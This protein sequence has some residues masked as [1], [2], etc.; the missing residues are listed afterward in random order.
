[1]SPDAWM[2]G[3]LLGLTSGLSP[4]PLLTLVISETLRRGPGAGLKVAAAPLITDAPV[5]LATVLIF[6]RMADLMAVIGGISLVGAGALGYYAWES[7]RFAGAAESVAVAATPG[8]AAADAGRKRIDPSLVRGIVTNF[9]N[10]HLYL[11]WISV[12]GPLMSDLSAN[13]GMA[14]PAAFLAAFY[15]CL[16]GAKMVLALI[17]GRFRRALRSRGYVAVIRGLG[18]VLLVFAVLFARK[19]LACFGLF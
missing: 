5:I 3:T 4:G 11:F 16:V 6:S 1:M 8:K 18:L 7:L 10:P 19:G 15:V 2:S 12:G 13:R 9:L 14:G 17:V